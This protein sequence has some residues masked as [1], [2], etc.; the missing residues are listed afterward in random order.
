MSR[1]RILADYVSSGDELALKAPLASPDFTGTV[2]LTG[3]TVSLDDDEISLDKV[4]G[5]TLGTGTIGGTSVISTSG[6]IT[7]TGGMTVDGATVFNEA[8]ADVDFRIEGNGD[9]N[10]FYADAG[11]DRI[12]IGT[13]SPTSDLHVYSDT[14]HTRMSI[15]CADSSGD[16][17]M[18]QSR[19]DGQFWIRNDSESNNAM[20]FTSDGNV[21][22]SA[23]GSLVDN[24]KGYGS[25][26]HA[27]K[28]TGAWEHFTWTTT[29]DNTWRNIISAQDTGGFLFCIGGDSG[30]RN[31]K[32]Y[33]WKLTSPGYGVS[34]MSQLSSG[35]G[36]WNS[37]GFELSYTGN[38][39]YITGRATSYYSSSAT[40]TFQIYFLRIN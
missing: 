9:A 26:A 28:G 14:D 37:G 29:C 17:W 33:S 18:F 23:D 13:A 5:G 30:T 34:G 24:P 7:T 10:L 31:Q 36:G 32:I 2:D 38:P 19:N 4:N 27:N 11:N 6:A 25:S 21:S 35:G 12:G 16:H 15:Q 20:V 40:A 39:Y 8:S 3:T 22:I 1:A